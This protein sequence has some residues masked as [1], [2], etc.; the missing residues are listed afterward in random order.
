M[1]TPAATPKNRF[2]QKLLTSLFLVACLGYG[3]YY[4]LLFYITSEPPIDTT[5]IPPPSSEAENVQAVAY[6]R[7]PVPQKIKNDKLM[8]VS[9]ETVELQRGRL[10]PPN[11]FVLNMIDWGKNSNS[12]TPNSLGKPTFDLILDR[13]NGLVCLSH[14]CARLVAICPPHAVLRRQD[15]ICESFSSKLNR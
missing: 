1:S 7:T 11:A 13:K 12:D 4:G 2:T 5:P 9:G 10:A 3:G 6:F 15:G 14:D 8:L